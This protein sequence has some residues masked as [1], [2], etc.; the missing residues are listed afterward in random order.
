MTIVRR[1]WRNQLR[2]A[3][4]N[5]QWEKKRPETVLISKDTAYIDA[6]GKIVRE[7]LTR[8]L[9]SEYGLSQYLYRTRPSRRDRLGQ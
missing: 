4:G 5:P 7:T 2:Q 3:Q 8:P 1:L 9:R 6:S